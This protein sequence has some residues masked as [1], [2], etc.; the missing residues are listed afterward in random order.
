MKETILNNFKQLQDMTIP[1]Y[2]L[3]RKWNEV[4]SI[5][6]APKDLQRMWEIKKDIW[7]PEY[8]DDYKKLQP[9]MILADTPDRKQT[10]RI[11]RTFTSTMP[12]NQSVG[13]LM[14]FYVIDSVTKCYLGV[15]SIASDFISLGGRDSH[16]GWTF[17]QRIKKKM[18]A[19]T[20]MG[21]TIVPTQPLGF[22]YTGGKLLSL[23]LCSDDVVNQWNEKYKEPLVGI[24]TTS[25]YGGF[26]QYTRLKYWKKCGTTEG[27]IPLEPTDDVYGKVRTWVK[28]HYPDDFIKM[29]VNKDKILS[30]PKN[31]MLTFAYTKLNIKPPNNHA[32]RGVYF[33]DLYENTCNLLNMKDTVI[34]DKK[35]DN[36][37]DILVDLWK[38]RYASKRIKS[39]LVKD[40]MSHNTLFYDDLIGMSWKEAKEKYIKEIGR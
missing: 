30:R 26:S 11:L 9:R 37:F 25:L 35:F 38:D 5:K 7:S 27:L 34:G 29:T 20:A 10:W 2:T 13:R 8:P 22:N 15:I 28:E 21:S 16:I 12:W 1:E 33:C 3:Y 4:N 23:L 40:R 6:W 17:D 39:L 19:Y 32:P 24:T 36:S 18:L 31:K 14:F